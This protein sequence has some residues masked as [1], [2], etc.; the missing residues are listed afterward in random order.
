MVLNA[1]R[2]RKEEANGIEDKYANDD[3]CLDKFLRNV[4]RLS[5]SCVA[6]TFWTRLWQ[7]VSS[8][9]PWNVLLLLY[10][11]LLPCPSRRA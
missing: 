6:S 7:L 10:S 3:L 1:K 5:L 4:A 2:P 9:W 8:G 11:Q